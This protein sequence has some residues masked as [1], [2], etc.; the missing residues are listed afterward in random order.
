MLIIWTDD[1]QKTGFADE[2]TSI[3]TAAI[4]RRA[5]AYSPDSSDG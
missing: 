5:K 2:V 1:S 4:R 3:I